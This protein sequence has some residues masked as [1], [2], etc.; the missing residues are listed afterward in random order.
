MTKLLPISMVAILG[1]GCSH[2]SD[3]AINAKSLAELRNASVVRTVYAAKGFTVLQPSFPGQGP[4]NMAVRDDVI[5]D[6][7]VPDPAAAMGAT[8]GA[9]LAASHGA[10]VRPQA[11][12]VVSTDVAAIAEAARAS[13]RF[14]L[15]VR[16][17]SWLVTYLPLAWNSYGLAYTAS[18]RLIDTESKTIVAQGYCNLGFNKTV[19][20]PSLEGMLSNRAARLKRELQLSAEECAR[21]FSAQMAIGPLGKMVEGDSVPALRPAPSATVTTSPVYAQPVEAVAGAAPAPAPQAYVEVRQPPPAP[22][23]AGAGNQGTEYDTLMAT[24]RARHN[25]LNP[26]SPYFDADTYEW[27]MARQAEHEKK[28]LAPTAAL[29]RA[30]ENLEQN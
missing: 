18:A 20:P 30:V 17:F 13:A 5:N 21:T 8:L 4:I 10:Q 1:A 12:T 24:V 6:F 23:L 28:G 14:A 9:A 19:N 29:R 16:T 11:I 22:A 15:D 25:K 3:Q 7:G 2:M 26:D 27:L